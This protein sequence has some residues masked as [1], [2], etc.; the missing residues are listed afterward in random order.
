MNKSFKIIPEEKINEE[1]LYVLRKIRE[2]SLRT[3]HG[4]PVEY[5]VYHGVI[6]GSGPT[7]ENEVKTLEKLEE[8]GAIK[9]LARNSKPDQT[10]LFSLE[11]EGTQFRE[12]YDSYS[13][14][15]TKPKE[16]VLKK[17]R[18][19][20]RNAGKNNT[21]VG[22]TF[23]GFD[24]GIEDTGEGTVSGSNNFFTS[25]S[26]FTSSSSTKKAEWL[27]G[28]A[29]FVVAVVSIPWW[30]YWFQSLQGIVT[31]IQ[32]GPQ[33]TENQTSTTTLN[34]SDIFLKYNGIDTTLEQRTFLAKYK[35][36][37]VVGS[38]TFVDIDRPNDAFLVSIRI[39]EVNL[40]SCFFD[41]TADNEQKLALLKKGSEMKFT[42]TFTTSAVWGG[43]WTVQNCTLLK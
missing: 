41:P 14:I 6:G 17:E 43:G 36:V 20:I 39:S 1:R 28:V 38:G 10:E 23:V 25:I 19:G 12:F 22:N 7:N 3:K 30:P 29:L 42:G 31:E 16:P 15:Y 18:V 11:L 4:L 27:S 9:I 21:F 40:V 13:E 5:P 26:N 33:K 24:V 34:I 37:F 35:D 2:H 8:L 32:V